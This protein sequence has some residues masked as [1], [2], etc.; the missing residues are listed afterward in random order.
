MMIGNCTNI[1]IQETIA[2][3]IGH[4]HTAAPVRIS[5]HAGFFGN[6]FKFKIAFVQVKF[7][8]AFAV[9]RKINIR[10]AVVIDIAG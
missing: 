10:Q 2:V 1:N 6:V 8:M 4:G 7:I 3:Y 5:G 9:G